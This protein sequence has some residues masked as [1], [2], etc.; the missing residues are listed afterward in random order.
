VGGFEC[1]Q[2]RVYEE[3]RAHAQSVLD[4]YNCCI[5]AYGQT[6]SGKTHTM[7]GSAEDPGVNTR[8]VRELFALS[9]NSWSGMGAW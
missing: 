6:G 2:E 8:L 9:S 4:G 1:S 3:V 5:F 7:T